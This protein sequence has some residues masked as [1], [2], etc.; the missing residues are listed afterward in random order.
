M[1]KIFLIT[2]PQHEYRIAYLHAWSKEI[3]DFATQKNIDFT[4]FDEKQSTKKNVEKYLEKR[5]PEF[6]I[7]NGHGTEDGNTILGHDDEE[8]I[9]VGKNTHLLKDA[10]VYA[11]ACFSF[12]GVGKD[13]IDNGGKAY[14]GY[15]GPFSWVHSANRECNPF[16]DRIAEPFKMISNEIAISILDGHTTFEAHTKAKELCFK[17]LRDFS[18]TGD[19]DLD[20]EI[21]FWLFVDMQIQEHLGNKD[22]TF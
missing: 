11:R 19:N 6:V 1:S 10:I 12:N 21:R 7:F 13:V 8:L 14:I 9:R 22:S 20:K 5:K 2:R 4:D 17:L 16:K 15:T 3:L 18:S